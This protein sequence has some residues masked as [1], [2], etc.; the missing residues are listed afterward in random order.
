MGSTD[1]QQKSQGNS[2]QETEFQQIVPE[3]LDIY[4]ENKWTSTLA[5]YE[6]CLEIKYIE[7]WDYN[8]SRRKYKKLE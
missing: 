3:K 6:N 2:T 1:F 4:K 8:T 5:S 7:T